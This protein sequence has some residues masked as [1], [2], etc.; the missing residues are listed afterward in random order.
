MKYLLIAL[1]FLPSILSAD[2]TGY[3]YIIPKTESVIIG[4]SCL[5]GGDVEYKERYKKLSRDKI[6]TTLDTAD[7]DGKCVRMLVV[8]TTDNQNG[9]IG[10]YKRYKNP[11]DMPTDYNYDS[12]KEREIAIEL[13]IAKGDQK[14]ADLKR[15]EAI[16]IVDGVSIAEK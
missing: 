9:V 16:A 4:Y 10:T 7:K 11:Q 2:I 13:E 15:A 8:E 14:I 5:M 12:V 1:L 6:S 3:E